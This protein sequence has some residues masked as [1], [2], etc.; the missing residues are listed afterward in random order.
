MN[1]ANADIVPIDSSTIFIDLESSQRGG[2]KD[3]AYH[4]ND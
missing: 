4:N 1:K 3:I 2:K